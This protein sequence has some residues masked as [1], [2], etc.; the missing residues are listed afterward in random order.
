MRCFIIFPNRWEL[1]DLKR[2]EHLWVPL[3]WQIR[4]TV[5][6]NKDPFKEVTTNECQKNLAGSKSKISSI[7]SQS[8]SSG[9][10]IKEQANKI[11]KSL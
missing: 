2:I 10:K 1:P 11:I 9:I 7:D 3:F 5:V 6:I 8:T 4:K